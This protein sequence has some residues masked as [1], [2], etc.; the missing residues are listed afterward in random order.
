M[1]P[2]IGQW[3]EQEVYALDLWGNM[4]AYSQWELE[5]ALRAVKA[6]K[7]KLSGGST[8]LQTLEKRNGREWKISADEELESVIIPVLQDGSN[9]PILSE[10][11][12]SL[13]GIGDRRW[14]VDP[15]DGSVNFFQRIPI[16]CI[17]VGLWVKNKP[18]LGVVLDLHNN[19]LFTG[20]IGVGAQCN[21]KAI[22]VN[23]AHSKNPSSAI[24]CTGFSSGFDYSSPSINK[25]I[26][27]CSQ[28][29]K[30][31]MLG[32]AALMLCYVASGKCDSYWENRIGL[33][34]IAAGMAIVAAAGG[35]FRLGEI[36]VD[37]RADAEAA[38]KSSLLASQV[39]DL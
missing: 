38:S 33:W 14:I 23:K 1:K 11:I 20:V 29:G 39:C 9:Y 36:T 19:D 10:E 34:D 37:F 16:Y 30:V 4:I 7:S 8:P 6:A 21:G 15:L 2:K 24:L 12:G 5:L 35:E 28:F 25:A 18:V 31:R 3:S 17:S 32:S 22:K 26:A 27:V 13:K